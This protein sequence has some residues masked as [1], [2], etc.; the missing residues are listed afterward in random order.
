MKKKM[1]GII[2]VTLLGSFMNVQA[3]NRFQSKFKEADSLFDLR[4]VLYSTNKEKVVMR[5]N[6][7]VMYKNFRG[8]VLTKTLFGFEGRLNPAQ[9]K[10]ELEDK[11]VECSLVVGWS[12]YE[13]DE[14]TELTP[15]QAMDLHDCLQELSD[16]DIRFNVNGHSIENGSI[17]LS[18]N[19]YEHLTMVTRVWLNGKESK[20]LLST[21]Q[22]WL[23]NNQE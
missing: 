19:I 2:L 22:Q 12:V 6:I 7:H 14:A 11:N 21:I 1:L 4:K 9:L 3:Q 23:D 8:I 5:R 16:V 13:S 10:K 15:S 17:R 18:Y 20:E